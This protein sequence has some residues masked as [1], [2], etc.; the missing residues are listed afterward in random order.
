MRPSGPA[1]GTPSNDPGDPAFSAAPA[2]AGE[3][4]FYEVYRDS[5]AAAEHTTTPHFLRLKEQM[6]ELVDGPVQ[7]EFLKEVAGVRVPY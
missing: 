1:G 5:A 7:L 3:L 6:R 4:V 2:V